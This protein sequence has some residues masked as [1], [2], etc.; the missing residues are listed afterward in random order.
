ATALMTLN[1]LWQL[2]LSNE[3]LRLIGAKLGAD[4][5]IFIFGKDAIAEG[6]GEV[7]TPIDLPAQQFLLLKPDA[8]IST[9]ELFTHPRLKRDCASLSHDYLQ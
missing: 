2:G 6:I 8:H 4:V 1:T 7:L 3:Q 5:P 9:A